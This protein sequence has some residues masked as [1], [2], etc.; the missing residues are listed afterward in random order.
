MLQ[1]HVLVQMRPKHITQFTTLQSYFLILLGDLNIP[2]YRAVEWFNIVPV[3]FDNRNNEPHVFSLE[4]FGVLSVEEEEEEE[5]LFSVSYRAL[6]SQVT[7]T[8]SLWAI[9]MYVNKEKRT[10]GRTYTELR[11]RHSAT[12]V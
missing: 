8:H 4:Q 11:P 12:C 3:Y 5:E 2:F 10:A 9:Y 6:Q 7:M 1:S